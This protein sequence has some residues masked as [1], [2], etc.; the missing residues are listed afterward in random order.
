GVSEMAQSACAQQNLVELD[1]AIGGAFRQSYRDYLAPESP[2]PAAM[3][4][5]T[6]VMASPV[7]GVGGEGFAISGLISQ[8]C[9]LQLRLSEHGF[10]ARGSITLGDFYIRDELVFGP[11][12]V[13]AYHLERERAIHPRMILSTKV[14]DVHVRNLK[15]N[16][17]TE[18]VPLATL[19]LCDRDGLAFL[20]Y[21]EFLLDEPDDP[22]P[23]L[24]AHRDAL[25]GKLA[26]YGDN[27]RVWEKY[28]WVAEYHNHFCNKRMPSNNELLI[29]D[30]DLAQELRP[31]I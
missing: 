19:L 5:D 27:S 25:A 26:T 13:E 23:R 30:V 2:W 8:A 11:A 3:F 4:S 20:N 21:L 15:D 7:E 28:R 9:P 17:A 24:A 6:L 10:F 29:P 22:R 18:G 14:R 16:A 31:V 1:R 12:L